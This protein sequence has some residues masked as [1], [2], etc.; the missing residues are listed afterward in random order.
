MKRGWMLFLTRLAKNV[1]GPRSSIE[2]GFLST[3]TSKT[4]KRRTANVYKPV[5][6][7]I[8]EGVG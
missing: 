8:F 5:G 6:K 2:N 4:T 3:N 1:T 7:D